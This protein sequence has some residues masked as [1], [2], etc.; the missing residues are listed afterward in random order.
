MGGWF[1]VSE[2]F[3]RNVNTVFVSPDHGETDS[4]VSVACDVAVVIPE[5]VAVPV[6]KD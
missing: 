4:D 5:L 1:D 3:T 6:K 2:N